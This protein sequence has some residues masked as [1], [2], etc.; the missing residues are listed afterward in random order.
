MK[1]YIGYDKKNALAYEVC[2]ASL[3]THAT[4]PLEIIPVKD[5]ILRR[6]KLFWRSY[7]VDEKGQHVDRSDRSAFSTDFSFTRFC[8]PALAD[9]T[10]N[11]VLFIDSDILFRADIGKVIALLD[12]EHSVFCVKHE[13]K[14]YEESKMFGLKQTYYRRKNWSSFMFINPARC[15]GLTPYAVNNWSGESLH[16][17]LWVADDLI[18]G[19]P[20]RWNYLLNCMEPIE[21]PA[22]VHFTLGTPDM[23]PETQKCRW[24]SE[25]QSYAK[26]IK[27]YSQGTYYHGAK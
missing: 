4:I 8:I 10:D 13:H 18:G 21:D 15:T 26:D 1:I 2:V 14:A 7:L 24:T 9:Y 27:L 12:Q 6:D 22:V 19:L 20:K 17:M 23:L 11:W 25:W 16:A 3:I 5:W